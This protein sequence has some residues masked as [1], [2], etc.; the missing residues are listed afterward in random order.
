MTR[1]YKA[2]LMGYEPKWPALT[3]DFINR[4]MAESDFCMDAPRG[5]RVGEILR[6]GHTIDEGRN[7]RSPDRGIRVRVVA[8]S[9]HG[10][11][12]TLE[13]VLDD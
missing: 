5:L 7:G 8:L 12:A 2:Y 3:E 6:T 9:H 1:R 13:E 4:T 11:L 10:K